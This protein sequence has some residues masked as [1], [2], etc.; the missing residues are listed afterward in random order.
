M[1]TLSSNFRLWAF[2]LLAGAAAAA[3]TARADLYWCSI[4]P[5]KNKIGHE[6]IEGAECRLID[7]SPEPDRPPQSG[8]SR[9]PEAS[10]KQ[11]PGPEGFPVIS[12][13]EQGF[14][15]GLR[16]Q[17]LQYELGKEI[18][19]LEGY[20]ERVKKNEVR[21]VDPILKDFYLSRL[22]RHVQNIK[23]LR[24]ELARLQ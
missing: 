12:E 2:L 3:S 23:A 20:R 9:Q 15:D 17:I 16:K 7:K 18:E 19:L 1:Q 5:G 24:Q 4:A 8:S 21:D 14:R 6:K 11:E 13:G 22:Q 10:E